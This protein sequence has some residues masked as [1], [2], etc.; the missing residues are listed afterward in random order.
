MRPDEDLLGVVVHSGWCWLTARTWWPPSDGMAPGWGRQLL[1][2]SSTARRSP[3][4]QAAQA[5][6]ETSSY[7]P[8]PALRPSWP[9]GG[10]CRPG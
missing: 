5:A 10:S 8:L 3:A 7:C 9:G 4:G 2:A 6:T 1:H